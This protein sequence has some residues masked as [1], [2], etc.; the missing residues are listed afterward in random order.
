MAVSVSALAIVRPCSTAGG[1]ITAS[2]G[3]GKVSTFTFNA[4]AARVEAWDGQRRR[5]NLNAGDDWRR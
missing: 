3:D 4:L 1:T 2:D 5:L